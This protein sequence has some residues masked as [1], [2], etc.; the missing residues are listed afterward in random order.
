M[1]IPRLKARC[2]APTGTASIQWHEQSGTQ[3]HQLFVRNGS[4]AKPVLIDEFGRSVDVLWSPNGGALAITEHVKST[5]SAV[6]VVK[7]NAP[8]HPA[9]AS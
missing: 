4:G 2:V 9:N 1:H 8:E 3:L 6:W 5:D 7:L